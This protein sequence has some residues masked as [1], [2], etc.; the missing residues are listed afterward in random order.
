MQI[1]P[2]LAAL[3][4][5]KLTALL[6]AA[7][8]AFTCAIVTN[9]V[10][11]I[12]QQV[13]HVSTP[14]GL[15]ENTLSIVT[16]D[17]L[18]AGAHPLSLHQA[19]LAALRKLPGVTSAAIIN[20]VPFANTTVGSGVCRSLAAAHA[21]IQALANHPH[22]V[23]GCASVAQYAGGPDSV[24]TLGLRLTSGRDF[25]PDEYITSPHDQSRPGSIP[26]LPAI[27]I[28][29]ALAAHLYSAHPQHA[30]GQIVYYGL[31]GLMHGKGSRVVGVMASLHGTA[32]D[33]MIG[34]KAGDS[35]ALVPI[36]QSGDQVRFALRS[37][38]ADRTRVLHEAVATLAKRR[39][40]RQIS[41]DD[42]K[43][44]TQIRAAYFSRDTTMIKLLLAAAL[45]LLFVTALGI[46]GLA[47]FWVGERTRSIGIRRAVG[48]TRGSIL[49]YFQTE[50]FLVVGAGILVGLAL[51][52]WLNLVLMQHYAQ[53]HL[54][55]WYLPVGAALLWLLGQLA[56]LNPALRA[57]SVPPVAATRST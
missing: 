12:V 38:L 1:Q 46:G 25:Y 14:S 13:Q 52:V 53:P 3:R 36:E 10:F 17:D 35:A 28:S 29:Q 8:V 22:I 27:I 37:Q 39:P 51:A 20:H 19:D 6:L 26:A 42:A 54:P 21:Q 4:H 41:M 57:A 43:T 31:Q 2:I 33:G 47:S 48:A 11:L 44:Y 32:F 49:R 40:Q 23:P 34:H 56:V 50:N 18:D 9:A 30:V 7:Q 16:V 5:H 55:L 24:R 15:A 45:G